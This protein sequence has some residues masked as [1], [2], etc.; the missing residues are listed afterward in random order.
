M[1]GEVRALP[2]SDKIALI[3]PDSNVFII[4]PQ[5]IMKQIIRSVRKHSGSFI[6]GF[7]GI[8]EMEGAVKYRNAGLA[9]LKESLD[10]NS[11]EYLYDQI[12]GASVVILDGDVLGT[13]TDIMETGSND[14]YV[15]KGSGREYLIPAIKDVIHQIDLNRKCIYIKVMEGL[16]D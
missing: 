14:V 6:I 2:I 12:I 10:L 13:V 15:V 11:D 3:Q 8:T 9:V 5:A 16:L 1:K 4:T 7:H